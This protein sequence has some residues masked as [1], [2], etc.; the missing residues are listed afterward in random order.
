MDVEIVK[1][2][3]GDRITLKKNEKLYI[4]VQH[5]KLKI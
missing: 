2:Y 4:K 5:L 1:E 3:Q